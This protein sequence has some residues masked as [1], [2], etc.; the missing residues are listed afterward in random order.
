MSEVTTALEAATT[1]FGVALTLAL[2]V[3]GF[4]LGRRWLR[5]ISE[6]EGV[7]ERRVTIPPM[8]GSWKGSQEGWE[9]DWKG[10]HPRANN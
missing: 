9:A 7:P 10:R 6:D 8:S 1:L 2:F 3:T 4:V 5:K